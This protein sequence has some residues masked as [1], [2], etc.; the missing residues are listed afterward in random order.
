MRRPLC[1]VC[2]AFVVS[3]FISLHMIP[4]PES[5]ELEEGSQVIYTGEVYH[6]EY[7]YNK[8]LLY[9]RNVN[10]VSSTKIPTNVSIKKASQQNMG[11]LCYVKEGEEPKYGSYVLISGEA[12]CFNKQRNPGG[13]DQEMYYRIQNIDFA[14][15]NAEI[16]AESNSYSRYHEG[17]YQL[18]RRLERVFDQTMSEK[19]ASIMKAMILGNKAELDRESKQLYQKSGISHIRG[20]NCSMYPKNPVFKPFVTS[21]TFPTCKPL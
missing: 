16:L 5:T 3:V 19:E 6:K 12:T 9:L 17:L 7:R 13:F 20:I 10:Q 11:I 4:L 2:L 1:L 18:R 21:D 8:L 15:K 14:M